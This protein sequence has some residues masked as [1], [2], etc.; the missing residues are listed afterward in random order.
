[1]TLE[2]SMPANLRIGRRALEGAGGIDLV[3]D[4]VWDGPS[5]AWILQAEIT[6][7]VLA[8]GLIPRSTEWFILADDAYPWG[9]IGLY[10]SVRNSISTTHPHQSFNDKGDSDQPWRNGKL[11]LDTRVRVLGRTGLDQEPFDPEKRL[12]WHVRRTQ[13]WLAA[14]SRSELVL[15][16][17]P[18]ELPIF[19]GSSIRSALIAFVEGPQSYQ[20]WQK[21]TTRVGL[22]DLLP[23]GDEPDIFVANRFASID[24]Q[25]VLSP[26]WGDAL[27]TYGDETVQGIWML[28]DSCP[29]QPP[30]QAPTT[31][32]ELS[33]AF[34]DQEIDGI[35]LIGSA[36]RHIRDGKRH[37]ALIGFPIPE[38]AE[39]SPSQIHWQPILLPRLSIGTECSDG[40][41]PNEMGYWHR[42]KHELLAE[43]ELVEWFASENW[44]ATEIGRRGRLSKALTETKILLLGAGALGSAI[45]ELLVRGGTT[46]VVI[47]DNDVLQAGNLIR[48]TLGL[49]E[50]SHVKSRALSRRLN[51]AS[52][53]ASVI[54]FEEKFPPSSEESLAQV[55]QSQ[56]VVDCTASDE[57][58]HQMQSFD[59]LEPKFFASIWIGIGARR[60]YCFTV[61]GIDFPHEIL[62]DLVRPWL[63]KEADEFEGELPR[64]GIGCWH[65]VFP[66]RADDVWLMASAATKHL[67]SI[68]NSRSTFPQLDVF[69]QELVL[70]EFTGLRKVA[71]VRG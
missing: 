66:A 28:L 34:L 33:R 30:W 24:N 23:I 25:T 19:P 20:A 58:H 55:L 14:A 48:H 17:E 31:W 52:P 9:D 5:K 4:F 64:E 57:V 36:A 3:D 61:H 39:Q 69:E 1:M 46:N 2:P 45:S 54:G 62:R 15:P 47:L 10:P 29:V 21:I 26:V 43:D 16:G 8:S 6:A 11:C 27:S 59:W 7:E 60:L 63:E 12:L 71:S 18:F 38:T 32:G 22:V 70:S 65:P 41:R 50:I 51:L 53:H 40:F 49:N 42:D 44:A 37:M 13:D 68:V 35:E 56:I 67:T